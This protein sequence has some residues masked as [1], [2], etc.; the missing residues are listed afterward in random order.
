[1]KQAPARTGRVHVWLLSV[2]LALFVSLAGYQAWHRARS[3]VD[4]EALEHMRKEERAVAHGGPLGKPGDWPQWRGPRRDGVL[5]K[6]KIET[7]WPPEGP[8]VVWEAPAGAG[9][10]SPVV[11]QGRLF[12]LLRHDEYEVVLC[13]DAATGAERWR[14]SYPCSFRNEYGGGGP[15]S[16][17]TVDGN[18]VYTV[19]AAGLFHCLNATTGKVVWRRDLL[20]EFEAPL[21]EWGVSF[22]PLVEGSLVFTMPGGPNGRALAAF[23]KY[24]GALVWKSLD[25][26][27]GYTSPVGMT[28]GGL[29]HIVYFTGT[30]VVGV[31]ASDG[32]LL[33]RYPW[34][35]GNRCNIATPIIHAGHVFVSSGYGKGCALLQVASEGG[36]FEAKRVYAHTQMRNHFSSSVRV[37]EHIY[38]F[39]EQALTCLEFETGKVAWT[40]RRAFGKGSV[41]AAGDVL[42]VLGENGELAL[43]EATPTAFRRLASHRFSQRPQCWSAPAL[44]QGKLYV[45]DDE[46][47][48]CLEVAKP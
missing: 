42:V 26:P 2:L 35:I 44:A 37:G 8:R 43:V 16:T 32:R 12:M 27:A 45:R 24:S 15:R 1:M 47:I 28:C 34:T 22:S 11:S 10:S 5:P 23:D 13:L 6:A 17:P 25:D 38:G 9:F 33:W 3:A 36:K 19:G 48:V 46:K 21:P 7:S 4:P 20:R 30:S 39:D 40:E 14:Y 18:F 31:A 41:L 29:R